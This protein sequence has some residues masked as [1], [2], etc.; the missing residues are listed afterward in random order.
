VT[1]QGATHMVPQDCPK[2]FESAVRQF[3]E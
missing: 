1:I 3:M 2:E